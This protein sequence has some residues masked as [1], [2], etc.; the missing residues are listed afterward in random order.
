MVA[1]VNRPGKTASAL[2][3]SGALCTNDPAPIEMHAWFLPMYEIAVSG[4]DYV[5]AWV[6]GN[7]PAHSRAR[8]LHVSQ[9]SSQLH[10][11]STTDARFVD[12]GEIYYHV[13]SILKYAPFVRRVHIVTDNQKPPLIDSFVTEG[14]CDRSFIKIV[15]HDEI[16][17]GLDAARPN[18]N[19]LAIEAALWR[20]EGLAEHF[21]YGNDDFFLNCSLSP[22]DFFIDGKPVLHGSWVKRDHMSRKLRIRKLLRRLTGRKHTRMNFGASQANAAILIGINDESFRVNHHPHPMRLSTIKNYY[23]NNMSILNQ[24][25]GH[26]FRKSEQYLP[27]ALANHLEIMRH[28][29]V[30]SPARPVAFLL[31]ET[32]GDSVG[33]V[34]DMMRSG[35]AP[36]GC[37]QSFEK[38]GKAVAEQCHDILMTKLH[39]TLPKAIYSHFR[40][41]RISA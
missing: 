13:A 8:H 36:F 32:R 41:A 27:V 30:P 37:I 2:Q 14:L 38:L 24:Q 10:R 19:S 12:N 6:D 35:D 22:S 20:I 25:V 26:R 40:E 28:A 33:A 5:I 18:F 23:E 21:I 31:P 1:L 7:D 3:P 4:I 34:L 29:V 39:D 17:A 11:E 9:S 16:F 15:S